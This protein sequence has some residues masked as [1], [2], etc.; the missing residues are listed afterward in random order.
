M[1]SHDR[2][3]DCPYDNHGD[4]D[5]VMID[6]DGSWM[7]HDSSWSIMTNHDWS[8]D[9][10]KIMK[11]SWIDHDLSW[12]IKN[13]SWLFMDRSWLPWLVMI[14]HEESW[15]NHDSH[16]C[17]LESSDIPK[18]WNF[19]KFTVFKVLDNYCALGRMYFLRQ[20]GNSHISVFLE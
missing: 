17:W 3:M 1:I 20:H 19:T 18:F 7:N 10:I 12:L 5:L 13:W 15:L 16:D 4:H 6:H 8:M 2:S 11:K 14:D 9:Y